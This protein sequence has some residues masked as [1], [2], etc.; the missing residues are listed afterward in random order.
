MKFKSLHPWDVTPKQAMQIQNQLRNKVSVEICPGATCLVAGA[1]I[2]LDEEKKKGFA[3]VIV[4]KFP[5][6]VEVERQWAERPLTF[7]YI[8]GLLAFREAPILL[9]AFANLRT[10]PHVVI[11]DGQGIA[12][13]RRFGIASHMGVIIDKP[14]I[15]CAKSLLTG[16]YE[17]PGE[18]AGDSSPLM[19]GE[20][21]IGLVLRTRDGV[22]PIFISIGHRIDLENCKRIILQCCD[23][24]RI[25]KPTREADHF[26]ARL[27]AGE[28]PTQQP[29]DSQ[30]ALF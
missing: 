3:G 21:V 12:H 11:F 5:E 25:P 18:R 22:N 6:L 4:Y 23:G 24:V 19:D 30:L 2:C 7:P 17:E 9:E 13:P 27:K 20:E 26:V 10:E 14:T 16:T 1:D 28:R 8:P 15:G 29:D